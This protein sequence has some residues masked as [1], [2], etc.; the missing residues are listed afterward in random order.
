MIKMEPTLSN[1]EGRESLADNQDRASCNPSNEEVAQYAHQRR[2]MWELQ[3]TLSLLSRYAAYNELVE[4]GRV[5]VSQVT[6]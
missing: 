4:D 3:S 6:V 5:R 1:V 2:P